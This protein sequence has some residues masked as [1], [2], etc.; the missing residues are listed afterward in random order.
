VGRSPPGPALG[1]GHPLPV[2][3]R[4]FWAYGRREGDRLVLDVPVVVELGLRRKNLVESGHLDT[5]PPG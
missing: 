2:E 3:D 4:P 5:A 1:D